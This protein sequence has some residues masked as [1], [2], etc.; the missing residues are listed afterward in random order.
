M[1]DISVK[2]YLT[3]VGEETTTVSSNRSDFNFELFFAFTCLLCYEYFVFVYFRKAAIPLFN[4]CPTTVTMF[5]FQTS[6][7]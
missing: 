2:R 6:C 7:H 1:L 3:N 5:N 4:S